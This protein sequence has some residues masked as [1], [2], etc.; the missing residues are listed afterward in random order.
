M[1]QIVE[2]ATGKSPYLASGLTTVLGLSLTQWATVLGIV[3]TVVGIVL[4]TLTYLSN[5][6]RNQQIVK[7]SRKHQQAIQEIER[8]KGH[9]DVE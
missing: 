9:D 8:Q 1:N 4:A 7:D 3:G 5:R 2:Q 6:W